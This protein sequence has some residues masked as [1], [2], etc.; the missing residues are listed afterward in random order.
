MGFYRALLRLYP[1]SFRAEYGD[2]MR[3]VFAR[4]LKGRTGP[5]RLAFL[6]AALGDTLV[7]AARVHG[8]ILRQDLRYT[9]RSLRRTPGFTL[10]AILVSALGIGATTA[11]FSVAD[12]VLVRPLPFPDGDRLVKVWEN[13]AER[14]YG[15]MEPSPPTFL[16]WQRQATSFERLEAWMNNDTASL[17]GSGEPLRLTG[18]RVRG[19][20]F[21]LLGRQALLGRTLVESDL[22][23]T[24]NPIVISEELWRNRFAADPNLLGRV[25]SLDG[26]PFAVVGVMPADFHFPTRGTDF[27]RPFRFNMQASDADRGNNYLQVIGRLKPGVT[28]EAARAEL[29]VIT[30]Q[31]GQAHPRELGDTV[32]A[33]VRWRDDVAQQ[34]RLLLMG[35]V[36]AAICVL[37]IACA[38]LANLLLSRALSRRQEFAIRAAVGAS[39]DRLLRQMLTDSLVIALAGGVLGV[40]MAVVAAPL[41]TRLVPTVLPIAEAPSLDPRMLAVAITITVLTGLAFG[42]L[43][44]WRVGRGADG[45]ALKDSSRGSSSRATERLRTTLV[46]AEIVVSIVLLVSA[47]LLMQALLRVQQTDPGFAADNLLTMRT[48]L[49]RPQYV[50]TDPRLRFYRQVIDEVQALPGV[51]SAAYTSYLPMTMP[52]GVWPILTTTPD[53]QTEGAFLPPPV[54]RRASLRFVTPRYFETLG[55]PL[56]RGRDLSDADADAAPFVAVVSESFARQEFPG[57]DPIG[58]QFAMAFFV[59]T[60]VGVVGDVKVRGLERE[61]EPQVYLPASQQRGGM[62]I[63]YVPQDL[64]I[65]ASVPAASLAPAVRAIIAR[66]DPQLPI[67]SVR[68]MTEVVALQTAPRVTQLR[69]VGAF[70]M[71]AFLLAAIGIHGLLAFTVAARSREIGVRIALGASARD[72]LWMVMG[73]SAIMAGAGVTVGAAL[74]VAAGRA[75][76]ALLAGVEPANPQVLAGAIALVLVMALAGSVLPTLRALRVD[77]L[78]ATRAE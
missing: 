30:Q 50:N 14:G 37:L 13:Q 27:W 21:A 70:T 61:S 12:H 3:A 1:R 47:G 57:Q 66:A 74:A 15:R 22:D 59:R 42:V 10:T 18:A 5:R 71:A 33:L 62:L 6:L 44:A 55:V 31:L 49:P 36:A 9:F 41:L 68:M 78:E 46:V 28:P 34:P 43:P 60:I 35:L 64:A 45:S 2:E 19:G 39:A 53:G 38:N 75:M 48:S 32:A 65:R 52:G 69:V 16:D 73:R 11:T 29:T 8:D 56:L 40:L 23:S 17:V 72:I 51:R 24:D 58:R 4:E 7:N 54:Q 20:L 77:P 26:Q 67:T 63:G 76:Q 25:L